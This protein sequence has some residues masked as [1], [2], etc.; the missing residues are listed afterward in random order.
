MRHAAC[1]RSSL[2][3][4][5]EQLS[6]WAEVDVQVL[7][8]ELEV[9]AKLF[10]LLFEQHECLTEPLDLFGRERI[11][12]DPPQSLALHQLAD[13]LDERKHQLSETLLEALAVGFDAPPRGRSEP[14]ELI[15]EQLQI[16]ASG[17]QPVL[18][19]APVAAVAGGGHRVEPPGVKL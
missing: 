14:I 16:S 13:Q 17:Q 12:L 9:L 1:L 7:L 11:P 8:L 10:H 5:L 19:S 2:P 3:P 6:E 18:Q 15:P 4:H